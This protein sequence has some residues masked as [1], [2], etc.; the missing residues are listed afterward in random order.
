MKKIYMIFSM[1]LLGSVTAFAQGDDC[2][3]AVAITGPGIYS[4]DGPITGGNGNISG[5]GIF[6]GTN[7]DWYSF[8]PSCDGIMDVSNNIPANPFPGIRLNY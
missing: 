1:V 7:A 4:A 5:C 3:S 8:T 6:G 2:A